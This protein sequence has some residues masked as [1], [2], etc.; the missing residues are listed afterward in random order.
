[1]LMGWVEQLTGKPFLSLDEIKAQ[2]NSEKWKDNR[3]PKCCTCK[4]NYTY[5]WKKPDKRGR[6]YSYRCK[7]CDRRAA[8]EC[9]QRKRAREWKMK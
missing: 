4:I 2:N 3:A 6:I 7:E 5:K 8:R 1:M 9:K